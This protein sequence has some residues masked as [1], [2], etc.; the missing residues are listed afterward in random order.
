M[1]KFPIKYAPDP[2]LRSP[3]GGVRA[4]IQLAILAMIEKRIGFGIPIQ[5][6]FDLIVGTRYIST[7]LILTHI[8]PGTLTI[9]L[10]AEAASLRLLS[11]RKT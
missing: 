11:A 5:E 7:L 4:V 6:F 9:S 8:S 3:S 2:K 1:G 10:P